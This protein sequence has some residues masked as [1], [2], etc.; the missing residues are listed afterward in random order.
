MGTV[1]AVAI[2]IIGLGLFGT[3]FEL[4]EVVR[5]TFGEKIN[6]QIVEVGDRSWNDGMVRFRY[7]VQYAEQT[8]VIWG[9]WYESFNPLTCIFPQSRVGK[10]VKIRLD[11]RRM[12]IVQ[13]PLVSALF[14]AM[15]LV[16]C[17][18]GVGILIVI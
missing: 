2:A 3:L 5:W 4:L 16:V 1:Y 18:C 13:S 11:L 10:S 15:G 12:K 8:Y 9:P 6:A 14:G 17:L 7:S